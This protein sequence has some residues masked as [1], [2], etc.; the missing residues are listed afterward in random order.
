MTLQRRLFLTLAILA[1]S[2]AALV[3][4]IGAQRA[5]GPEHWV[6]TWATAVVARAPRPEP[7]QGRGGQAGPPPQA[8]AQA[9]VPP[10][11]FNNQTLREIV[12]TS[13]GGERVRVVLSNAFGTVPLSIGAAHVALREKGAAGVAKSDRPLTFGGSPT[14]TIPAGAVVVSDPATLAVSALAD[15]AIDI[16]LPDDTTAAASPLTI[17]TA[18]HQTSYVSPSGNFAGMPELPVMTTTGS[19]FFLS[20]VEVAAPEQTGAVVVLGDSITDGSRSTDDANR[21]WPDQLARRLM[22][23]TVRMG[24]LN[25][26]I[27]GNRV[28]SDGNGASAAARFDRDVLVQTG[29]THVIVMEGINDIGRGV[30]AA[31]LI[32]AHRQLIERAHASGLKVFGGT[33]T[34]ME[35]T[36]FNGYFT[37]EHEAV[38]RALNDWILTGKAY[39]GVIDFDTLVRDPNRPAKLLPQ[40]AADD[41]LHP[42]DAGYQ[43]MGNSVDLKLFTKARLR[44]ASATR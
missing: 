36:T 1:I 11:N 12:H 17:H 26:G 6:G 16:Y 7:V 8:P 28:L 13:I 44:T 15:L 38:R 22:A 4:T 40:Y 34:P 43:L 41:N 39:D 2:V 25:A 27:A 9:P 29:A 3:P 20:R 37:A 30:G 21:R 23:G 18:A 31:D 42:N 35:D 19:W 32:A 24:V 14:A 10:L 33:L 5:R